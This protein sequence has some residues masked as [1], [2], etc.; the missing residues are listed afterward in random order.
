[1][2]QEV[3]LIFGAVN[4]NPFEFYDSEPGHC[5]LGRVIFFIN[6]KIEIS[7]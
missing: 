4:P 2:L 5:T 7:K 1:M 3:A 6:L